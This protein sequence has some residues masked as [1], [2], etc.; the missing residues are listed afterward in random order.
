MYTTLYNDTLKVSMKDFMQNLILEN[1]QNIGFKVFSSVANDPFEKVD[2]S[3]DEVHLQPYLEVLYA[4]S[5]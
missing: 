4:Q 3:F 2:F 5:E 1:N